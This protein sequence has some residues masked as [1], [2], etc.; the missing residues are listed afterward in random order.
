MGAVVMSRITTEIMTSLEYEFEHK[1]FWIDSESNLFNWLCVGCH[2]PWTKMYKTKFIGYYHIQID[3]SHSFV[4]TRIPRFPSELEGEVKYISNENNPADY[5][6]KPIAAHKLESWCNR[7][8]CKFPELKENFWNEKATLWNTNENLTKE[9]LDEK[10]SAPRH[11]G[12]LKGPKRIDE[13]F[14]YTPEKSGNETRI[15]SMRKQ[16]EEQINDISIG[17][18]ITKQYSSW[19]KLV[20]AVTFL[21]RAFR[22]FTLNVT[23]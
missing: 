19:I 11:R 23:L 2:R 6:T 9:M 14:D 1:W 20:S 13:R 4:S 21:K 16:A 8:F 15:F 7:Q 5:L 12:K 22:S 3:I 10:H 17:D 18:D